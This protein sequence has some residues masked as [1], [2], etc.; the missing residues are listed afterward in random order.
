MR[1]VC[2]SDTHEQHDKVIVPEGDVLIHAGDYT[3]NGSDKAKGSFLEWFLA[4]PHRYKF[5]IAGNHDFDE[6]EV[7]QTWGGKAEYLYESR[8]EIEGIKFWGS[9]Y[10][11]RFGPWAFMYDRGTD[12]WKNIPKDTDVLITHGPALGFRDRVAGYREQ[13][14][15]YDLRDAVLRIKPKLH[16]F[17]HIHGSYGEESFNG[18]HFVNASICNE[19]YDPVNEPIV[20][21]LEIP[22]LTTGLSSS[23][24]N[25]E[26][27]FPEE[28]P[29]SS[30]TT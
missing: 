21:D 22:C 17:G 8:I 4:K 16:V 13:V 5:Y 14:G 18:T 24:P 26:T 29:A 10:T 19:A 20:F 15:C 23:A 1:I 27:R 25:A 7:N 11:P 30:I 12:R 3:W 2:I 28:R 9:P 6:P